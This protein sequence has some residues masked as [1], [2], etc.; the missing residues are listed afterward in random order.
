MVRVWLS[1]VSHEGRLWSPTP[2]YTLL[3]TALRS[4]LSEQ[5][6]ASLITALVTTSGADVDA[7]NGAGQTPLHFAFSAGRLGE[8]FL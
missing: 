4:L 2:V 1:L 3:S 8:K 6:S 7:R 5:T